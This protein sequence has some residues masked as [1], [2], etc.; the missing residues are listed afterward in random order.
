MHVVVLI[1]PPQSIPAH[2]TNHKICG[3]MKRKTDKT[4]PG[5]PLELTSRIN[6]LLNL[7]LHLPLTLPLDPPESKYSFFLDP[8]EVTDK[9]IFGAFGNC[10]ESCFETY[11]AKDQ[12]IHFMEQGKRLKVLTD[13]MKTTV[14]KMTDGERTVFREV[15]LERLIRAA[16][17]DGAKIPPK[18]SR[19]KRAGSVDLDLTSVGRLAVTNKAV[20]SKRAR[21]GTVIIIDDSED[22]SPA[23]EDNEHHQ[24]TTPPES[25]FH[26]CLL[27]IEKGS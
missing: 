5:P 23:N 17:A 6:H 25:S 3:M 13:L 14:G 19:R 8:D 21:R 16:I 7:L 4:L 2:P 15:W 9:G 22:D 18:N 20:L 1:T 27:D 10:M 12:P 26:R 24:P 11:K